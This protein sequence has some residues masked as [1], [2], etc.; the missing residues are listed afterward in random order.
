MIGQRKYERIPFFCEVRISDSAGK[1]TVVA[2]TLDISLGGVGVAVS[3][4]FARGDLVAVSFRLGR[5]KGQ[6]VEERV[7]GR[8]AYFRADIE[9][10]R[11]GVEFLEPL[12]AAACPE[13]ARRV[14][15]L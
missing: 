12:N 1:K 7:F 6:V 4:P 3:T 8:V 14:D 11:I 10:N 5:V 9:G 15:R 13:L 2:N